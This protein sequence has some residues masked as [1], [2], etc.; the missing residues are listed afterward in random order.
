[1]EAERA[2]QLRP[3]LGE[4]HLALGLYYYYGEKN[5][6]RALDEFAVA[7]RAL[8]NDSQIG[9]FAAAIRR[10]QGHSQENLDLLKRSLTL[11]PGNAN[12]AAEI[13]YTY[14]F[15]HDWP[16]AIRM[17]ERV[18][19]L[20]PDSLNSK[21][22]MGYY[23]FWSKGTTTVLKEY[24]GKISPGVDPGGIVTRARWD[25][26]MIERDY[27]A[28][29][30]AMAACPLHE[31]QAN[32][33]P[34]P[35]SFYQGCVALARG[36][37]PNARKKFE[38]A[39]PAFGEAVRQ[40]PG[41]PIRHANLGLLCAFLDRKEDAIREGHRA[42]EL[43]PEAKDA[44]SGPWMNGY[45]AMIYARVGEL[46]SALPLLEHLLA[47]PGPIDNT[48]CCITYNDLRSRWQWDPVRNDP[49]FQ[50]L[51]AAPEPKTVSK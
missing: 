29:E 31:F 43:E 46:D 19:A 35:K 34:T 14:G 1:M 18:I 38:M 8:P 16:E 25:L 36:D 21:I 27:D 17:Q 23:D 6:D 39:L 47:S 22:F 4:G 15:L 3:D 30:Q 7:A 45:L 12:L 50:K 26:A 10:R 44:V 49:R 9:Y 33:Q 13:A 48:N 51:L 20:A 42:V 32:G 28:A 41:S 5:Y 37:R 24:L 40:A 11:D 2:L